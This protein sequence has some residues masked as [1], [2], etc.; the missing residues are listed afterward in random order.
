MKESVA[1]NKL[2]FLLPN[3]ALS[4]AW[5]FFSGEEVENVKSLWTERDCPV[6]ALRRT[7]VIIT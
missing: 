2:E 5:L 7:V 3:N 1:F 6:N 4:Q